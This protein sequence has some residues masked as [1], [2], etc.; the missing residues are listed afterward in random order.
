VRIKLRIK[1]Q[2]TLLFRA[3][4]PSNTT[5]CIWRCIRAS[6]NDSVQSASGCRAKYRSSSNRASRA[7]DVGAVVQAQAQLLLLRAAFDRPNANRWQQV[8]NSGDTR[9]RRAGLDCRR[10]DFDLLTGSYPIKRMFRVR[11][12]KLIPY[13]SKH[14]FLKEKASESLCSL[15]HGICVWLAHRNKVS[16]VSMVYFRS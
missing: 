14:V 9:R 4:C 6:V 2:G 12:Q 3:T 11:L 1:D 15:F 16:F 8:G 7:S 5:L 10:C 13:F